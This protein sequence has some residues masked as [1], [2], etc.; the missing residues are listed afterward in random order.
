MYLNS[1]INVFIV[2]DSDERRD[3]IDQP[4]VHFTLGSIVHHG[5]NV[6]NIKGYEP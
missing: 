6:H 1:A 5:S 3:G 4:D 2:L